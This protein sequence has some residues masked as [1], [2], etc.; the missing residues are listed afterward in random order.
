MPKERRN[1]RN[2]RRPR[3]RLARRRHTR[4]H[5][6]FEN[7]EQRHLLAFDLADSASWIV[8]DNALRDAL[9]WEIAPPAESTQ[10]ATKSLQSVAQGPAAAPPQIATVVFVDAGIEDH[11]LLVRDVLLQAGST[12]DAPLDVILLSADRDGIEQ[13][14]EHLAQREHIAAIH[15]LSHANTGTLTL[16]TSQLDATS[17]RR[18]E[19]QLAGWSDALTDDADILLYGC[20]LA[21]DGWGVQLIDQLSVITGADVAASDDVTGSAGLGG[22]WTLEYASGDVATS[23]LIQADTLFQGVL[24]TGNTSGSTTATAE[25][26]DF[27]ASSTINLADTVHTLDLTGLNYDLLITVR[28]H[29]SDNTRSEIQ[30]AE[31]NP[32]GNPLGNV[33]T[34]SIKN[35]GGNTASIKVGAATEPSSSNCRPA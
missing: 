13:I 27:S 17:L 7:L 14:S 22:N 8:G 18:Y 25:S 34:Y 21:E 20:N 11:E 32:G 28:N 9:P 19:R 29:A 12:I 24:V 6:S 10:S 26:A 33:V 23:G 2:P 1:G 4:Q 5:R 16:G 3:H 15:V 35:D 31:S 30:V